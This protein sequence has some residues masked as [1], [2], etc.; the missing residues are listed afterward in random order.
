MAKDFKR[1]ILIIIIIIIIYGLFN[2]KVT[3]FL[4]AT[5]NTGDIKHGVVLYNNPYTWVHV[6][7]R[8]CT[9]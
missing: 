5:Q 6:A 2:T 3:I 7:A 4:N 8:R 9:L 1:K